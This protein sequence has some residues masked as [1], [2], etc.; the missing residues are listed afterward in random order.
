[1]INFRTTI[2]KIL[3]YEK[4]FLKL[5]FSYPY[6]FFTFTTIAQKWTNYTTT[7]GLAD[8][9]VTSIAIDVHGYLTC[10]ILFMK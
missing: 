8:N 7:D 6:F 10:N 5:L 9:F 2:L 3:H 4:D 1:M